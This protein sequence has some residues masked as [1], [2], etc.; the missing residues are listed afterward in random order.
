MKIRT[1]VNPVAG[2]GK[3]SRSLKEIKEVL[4][5]L[6]GSEDIVKTSRPGE[7]YIMS[8][9]AARQGFEKVIAVGGDG[10]IREVA[11]GLVNTSTK[12]VIVPSGMGNDLARSLKIPDDL[13]SAARLAYSE[14]YQTIDLATDGERYFNVLGVGFPVEVMQLVN[15]GSISR[16]PGPGCFLL[17][18]IRVVFR[19]ESYKV[20]IDLDGKVYRKEALAVFVMNTPYTG[21]G[22]KLCPS[23]RMDDGFLDVVVIGT[24]GRRELLGQIPGVYRGSH[25][26]HPKFHIYRGKSVKIEAQKKSKVMIDGDILSETPVSA[27]IAPRTLKVA[28]SDK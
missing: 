19:M 22:L 4:G 16:I 6:G 25:V 28:V 23:A 9:E 3:A 11:S 13:K 26:D 20:K 18:I 12:L 2:R 8:R 27:E 17:A 21:G 7:G 10:T 5:E 15:K 14:K 1:I 24:V